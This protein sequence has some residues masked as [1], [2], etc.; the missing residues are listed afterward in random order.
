[1]TRRGLLESLAGF[2]GGQLVLVELGIAPR[3]VL[4]DRGDLVV[5]QAH[6]ALGPVRQHFGIPPERARLRKVFLMMCTHIRCVL[7][8][9]HLYNG[10]PFNGA[11]FNGAPFNG[12][13]FN[14][15]HPYHKCF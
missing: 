1:M 13:P 4:E 10:A 14:D 7:N 5:V 15:V 3:V 8:D 2:Q 9:V 6:R 11:P 12:T